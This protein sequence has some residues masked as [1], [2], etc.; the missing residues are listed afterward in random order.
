MA[1]PEEVSKLKEAQKQGIVLGLNEV[2]G[3][4]RDR[5]DVDELLLLHPKTFNLYLLALAYLQDEA[6][7]NKDKMG[8]FQIAGMLKNRLP[9]KL[10]ML[11]RH[12]GFMD[13]Q[14]RTGIMWK[15]T[16]LAKRVDTAL[17]VLYFFPHGI[18]L[19]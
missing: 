1:T 17:M 2:T 7:S 15:E 18:D 11:P 14:T 5:L 13:F 19:T 3:E 6:N 8:Y 12:K 10:L 16:P 9:L 4:V